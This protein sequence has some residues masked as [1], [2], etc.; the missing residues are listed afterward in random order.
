MN[1]T[2]FSALL[3][4]TCLTLGAASLVSA[5]PDWMQDMS[6][7]VDVSIS[8]GGE[9]WFIGTDGKAYRWT[10]GSWQAHGSRSDFL[11][12]D[13]NDD[14]AAALTDS[15]LLYLTANN[16]NWQPTGI[17]AQDLGIGG[18]KIWLAGVQNK[19]GKTITLS[20]DFTTSGKIDW[21]TIQGGLSY[22]DVDPQGRPW[23]VDLNGKV[24][25]HTDETGW[26]QDDKAPEAADIGAGG[27]GAL[28]I[29]GKD[30]DTKL[31]GG[32]VYSRNPQSGEWNAQKGRLASITVTPDGK[33]F[34]VN[35]LNWMIAGNMDAI[36]GGN[37]ITVEEVDAPV[38]AEG[39]KTL[40]DLVGD[41]I[42]GANKV[43]LS[44]YKFTANPETAEGWAEMNGSPVH[45]I[46]YTED[47][48][49]PII[50]LEHAAVD[51]GRY[52]E[53][54]RGSSLGSFGLANAIFFILPDITEDVIYESL[55]D[56]PEQLSGFLGKGD[57]SDLFPLELK[58]GVTVIGTW[59]IDENGKPTD[60]NVKTV[61]SAFNLDEKGYAIKGHFT[62]DQ[63]KNPSLTFKERTS[64]GAGS[65]AIDKKEMCNAVAK[66]ATIS[67]LDLDFDLPDYSPSFAQN[68]FKFH[69]AKFTLKEVD[70]K[71]EPAILSG[72]NIKMPQAQ[73][74]I[75][76]IRMAGKLSVQG[77]LNIV[78]NGIS[79]QTEGTISVA[80]STA[81]NAV[82]IEGVAF[83]SLENLIKTGYKKPEKNG[84]EKEKKEPEWGWD[85]PY[86]IDI[87]TLKS[88]AI[89][90]DFEQAGEGADLKRTLKTKTF[91]HSILDR[92]EIQ[93]FGDMDFEIKDGGNN[94]E[95]ENWNF[96][97]PGPIALNDLPAAKDTP[98]L[99]EFVMHD[100][101]IGPEEMFGTLDW[102]AKNT[103]GSA[104]LKIF[105]SA[106]NAAPDTSPESYLF[107]R[108]D[109]ITPAQLSSKFPD[110]IKNTELA[111]AVIG[112]SNVERAEMKIS[113]MPEK[114]QTIFD[115][116]LDGD[117]NI[118]IAKG[119][120]LG[121][122]TSP[123]KILS[124]K[125]GAVVTDT[126]SFGDSLTL[127]GNFELE[128]ISQEPKGKFSATL[129]DFGLK[130]IPDS[131][132]DFSN[133]RL[134]VS[135][136]KGNTFTIETDASLKVS[137][138]SNP[139]ALTGSIDYEQGSAEK[140]DL[141]VALSST[142]SWSEPFLIPSLEIANIG[143]EAEY[144]KDGN[145]ITKS[146]AIVG[147]GTFRGQTGEVKILSDYENAELKDSVINFEGSLKVSELM[148]VPTAASDI[149]D[150]TFTKLLLSTN[151]I[152]GDLTLKLGGKDV[153][154]RG[155]VISDDGAQVLFL[156]SDEQINITDIIKDIPTPMD[157]I[158]LPKGV[159]VIGSK[160]VSDFDAGDIPDVIYDQ[161]FDGLVD[162]E[163][164]ASLNV[165][166]GLMFLTKLDM[167][168]IP[169]L[170]KP[171]TSG[172]FGLKGETPVAGSIG[173]IY[174]GQP[175]F[176]FYT[177][178]KDAAPTLPGFV[179]EFIEFTSTDASVF[180]Q[181]Y[182]NM[183]NIEI[184]VSSKA[185]LKMRRL[186]DLSVQ[187][188][189]NTDLSVSYSVSET[190]TAIKVGV[191]IDDEWKDPL[192]LEGYSLQ[193]PSV[194]FGQSSKGTVINIHTERAEFKDGGAVKAFSFDMDSTWVSLAPTDL[195]LQFAKVCKGLP[196]T[197]GAEPTECEDLMLTPLSLARIQKS[198]YDLVFRAGSNLKDVVLAGV[199]AAPTGGDEKIATAQA[200]A[201]ALI[202]GF[203]DK[204]QQAS[205][206]ASK[207]LENS[208]LSFIGVR[209]PVI[210]F[211][212]PGSAPPS[213]PD[214]ERPPLG[215]GLHVA[216]QMYM[217][218]AGLNADLAEGVYKV[219]L[220]DGY[221]IE[222]EVTAPDPFAANTILVSGN[223]PFLGG[224]QYLRFDGNLE[225]PG[226]TLPGG[227]G[228]SIDGTFD[229]SQGGIMDQSASI[230]ADVTI[231]GAINREGSM[232]LANK[233]LNFNSPMKCTDIPPLAINGSINLNN[234][235]PSSLQDSLFSAF[236]L[237]VP[238]PVEC[239]G[240]IAKKFQELAEKGFESLTD[241]AGS[242]E[243][244]GEELVDA[245]QDPEEAA[246]KAA[247]K[248]QQLAE[249]PLNMGE[250]AADL[251]I[252]LFKTGA[253]KVPVIGPG[254]SSAAGAAFDTAKDL[255][256]AAMGALR[257]NEATKWLSD[258]IGA[259][260]GAVTG[261][262]G[263]AIG[264]ISDW[265]SSVFGKKKRPDPVWY[266]I[267][268]SRCKPGFHYWNDVFKQCFENGSIV[269]FDEQ[270]RA[271]DKVGDCLRIKY[272]GDG[273]AT[274]ETCFGDAPSQ[275]HINPATNQITSSW[276]AYHGYDTGWYGPGQPECLTVRGNGDVYLDS[277][278]KNG[279][280]SK[281]NYRA[282][283]KLEN[284]GQCMTRRANNTVGM[285]DCVNARTWLG[286]SIVANWNE[287]KEIPVRGQIKHKA[288]NM[289]WYWRANGGPYKL[290]DCSKNDVQDADAEK[291]H[292]RSHVRLRVI[293]SEGTFMIDGAGTWTSPV[294]YPCMGLGNNQVNYDINLCRNDNYETR[295]HWKA[296]GVENGILK[297][298]GHKPLKEV[299]KGEYV[300]QNNDGSCL[301]V[302]PSKANV[303][304]VKPFYH[305]GQCADA[306]GIATPD[307]IMVDYE[308]DNL[309]QWVLIGAED[310]EMAA[311][312]ASR[313]KVKPNLQKWQRY[314]I[315][316]E[317]A[318]IDAALKA[319]NSF[320][321][322]VGKILNERKSPAQCSHDEF[323]NQTF[324][325]CDKNE[326]M[327]FHYHN[328][329]GERL[330]CMR[331]RQ[332][333]YKFEISQNCK[334]TGEYDAV[335][336]EIV[337]NFDDQNRIVTS[338]TSAD[339]P[340]AT[341]K[342]AP[343]C[344]SYG[345]NEDVYG[346]FLEQPEITGEN[347]NPE[348]KKAKLSKVSSGYCQ[349]STRSWKYS[350]T[351]EL[352]S[353]N[354]MCIR[355]GRRGTKKYN[356]E[357]GR[358]YNDALQAKYKEISN[359]LHKQY[360]NELE[361]R[362]EKMENFR[363]PRFA[364]GT[365]SDEEM[366]EI[367]NEYDR[368]TIEL[369]I[370]DMERQHGI[371]RAQAQQDLQ[372]NYKFYEDST[373]S[374]LV[375]ADCKSDPMET[376]KLRWI[377]DLGIDLTAKQGLPKTAKMLF[378][379]DNNSCITADLKLNGA[380]TMQPCVNDNKDQY[381]AL[382]G[383]SANRFLISS[384]NSK[385]CL[386]N[387][388][389][390]DDGTGNISHRACSAGGAE[391]FIKKVG[392]GGT[393][394]IQNSS[395]GL[396]LAPVNET[397]GTFQKL[398]QVA[399]SSAHAISMNDV[400]SIQGISFE[401]LNALEIDPQRTQAALDVREDV[402][403]RAIRMYM[404]S[405]I[406]HSGKS[407]QKSDNDEAVLI[408]TE[409]VELEELPSH[410]NPVTKKFEVI[411]AVD[412]PKT[413]ILA[414]P[415][416]DGG[417]NRVS[418]V[419]AI[420][421]LD[422][423]NGNAALINADPYKPTFGNWWTRVHLQKAL[424]VMDDGSVKFD[425]IEEEPDFRTAATFKVVD[426]LSGED[427]K[428]S[429]E[430]LLKPGQFLQVQDG[431]FIVGSANPSAVS[432]DWTSTAKWFKNK[433]LNLITMEPPLRA[434]YPPYKNWKFPETETSIL[435][436]DY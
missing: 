4:F 194:E 65:Y 368:L 127:I 279:A 277:C 202:N 424:R 159:F 118:T 398:G 313:D 306:N 160:A 427:G 367:Q 22:V 163:R 79:T 128:E 1:K 330:G 200:N 328:A 379:N 346:D 221:L 246:Q 351:G 40:A 225:V 300:F 81:F 262:A 358:Q 100:I 63:L 299:L 18:G 71:I 132:L 359:R 23:G 66:N 165:T 236:A 295:N 206:G 397:E 394:K 90:G 143:F 119:L 301:Y 155:A 287:I 243:A 263:Q 425:Y 67:G 187:E 252:N 354:G 46:L 179:D 410:I 322:D 374:I 352:V 8:H 10:G 390:N 280:N 366:A 363:A 115:G 111:P 156:R 89:A 372:K 433:D 140:N 110:F 305:R 47:Q 15:G 310:R 26:I 256:N 329:Q 235:T 393:V 269:F 240:D 308:A 339:N 428:H 275:F 109:K 312:N 24:Y 333:K 218:V 326:N 138:M 290:E 192:G 144:S 153:S 94:V 355:E 356:L 185:D 422:R 25:V 99:D 13:A 321:N 201:T 88:F 181:S 148:D 212:T 107:A 332:N 381:F 149:A 298:H 385:T 31:G 349:S 335:I 216:G 113:D 122:V 365:V 161:I 361:T 141:T 7:G 145:D 211:G 219:N 123:E 296:L 348:L 421:L 408:Q 401:P 102:P 154:G 265:G 86:G 384:R 168:K 129:N 84:D 344:M 231:G 182:P 382:G 196:V 135:V 222:G 399:C 244:I 131:V 245:L 137:G 3:G 323:W 214:V 21:K 93:L 378:A 134:E 98:Y 49:N 199:K 405:Y 429:F 392:T 307:A 234:I 60:G 426:A 294:N 74:G 278:H 362:L 251:G 151:A 370:D 83:E 97:I 38:V 436:K 207:L 239:A 248:A 286:T 325:R 272:W 82:E 395:S 16:G 369:N 434:P 237:D 198:I 304:D 420:E 215:F 124:G 76:D 190:D 61:M 343:L 92:A 261:A 36:G 404:G 57:Y 51:L 17:R 340:W 371:E 73:A 217:D 125:Y 69:D 347:P 54:I 147:D 166:D 386:Y 285:D 242:V 282:D 101:D 380:V 289:C 319:T 203:S 373:E 87:L 409:M 400:N 172:V 193:K 337:F 223:L 64:E 91:S 435:N 345:Q 114:M 317:N 29:V 169:R 259:S 238:D 77:N 126:L 186:D 28:Y 142:E 430:S 331:F 2:K 184:G 417:A 270:S 208:P 258:G 377:P 171:V 130:Q 105:P 364:D 11:R 416:F 431:K 44:G 117:E 292:S 396:C 121:G 253:D 175:S 191:N 407:L 284:G 32:R 176:G 158:V 45:A 53:K 59:G 95:I 411:P 37:D 302:D 152:A 197:P 254:L 139:F 220:V 418:F 108:M 6:S 342:N 297:P 257:N 27:N 34:G 316:Q 52:I 85:S 80:G 5:A 68:A 402:K 56:V 12:I 309:A 177:I 136:L 230:A 318:R 213:R 419:H 72:M 288:S 188:L 271:P 264:A 338:M 183:P 314:R 283:M 35:S 241:P 413:D 14:D 387:A 78:C 293:D 311:F 9:K 266:A 233:T 224:A 274:V 327:V 55:A 39:D 133:S 406:E 255:K 412:V 376:G 43:K 324:K 357:Q 320:Q 403:Q 173:G 268:P 350:P 204:V 33:A 170:I 375:M 41:D 62:L 281:W 260:L 227:I 164:M 20:G 353:D 48:S 291:R 432:F 146:T 30:I 273:P 174:G 250:A 205:D 389:L 388:G 104:Y 150:A 157:Q 247:E 249:M 112:A 75:S 228:L 209:D 42:P 226:L 189:K 180:V 336:K 19:D 58:S 210:Y 50:A 423:L 415:G 391:L 195:A 315:R 360:E 162:D 178:V 70:G 232:S 341:I 276:Y 106:E 103:S 120:T 116:L 267:N 96:R 167:N 383:A 229:V 303:D 334:T 414:V